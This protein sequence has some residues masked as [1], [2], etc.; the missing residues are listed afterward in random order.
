MSW[1][2]SMRNWMK[3]LTRD[4]QSTALDISKTFQDRSDWNA[5]H[6]NGECGTGEA[7]SAA[8]FRHV[9]MYFREN[10]SPV[11]LID[12]FSGCG[13]NRAV[14]LTL[15]GKSFGERERALLQ[16]KPGVLTLSMNNSGHSFR[17]DFWTCVDDPSRFTRSIWEDG[18]MMKFVPMAHFEKRIWDVAPDKPS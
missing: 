3:I 12:R 6:W 9:P 1:T 8:S 17:T 2:N 15:N 18:R 7:I 5:L 10:G 13:G 14:F 4:P 16:N 11:D